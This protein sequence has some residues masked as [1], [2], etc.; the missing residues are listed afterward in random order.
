MPPKK[1]PAASVEE[2]GLAGTTILLSD[3]V[4]ASGLIDLAALR[5]VG[6]NVAKD[7]SEKVRF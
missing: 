2:G 1:K 4:S 6:I 7:T 5:T 3:A